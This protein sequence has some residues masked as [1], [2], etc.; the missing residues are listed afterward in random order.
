MGQ[1]SETTL[2]IKNTKTRKQALL[3]DILASVVCWETSIGWLFIG[4]PYK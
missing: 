4:P 2:D 3:A 1:K